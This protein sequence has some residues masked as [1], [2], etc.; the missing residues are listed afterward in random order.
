M[1]SEIE[2]NVALLTRLLDVTLHL[3]SRNLPFRGKTQTLGDVHNGNYLGTLELMSHYDPLLKDH[4][5]KVRNN[6]KGSRLAHYL[7]SDSQNEFIQLCAKRVSKSI[8][9]EREDAIYYSIIC[10]AT[11]DISHAEQN[12]LLIRYVHYNENE[13]E[14][15]ITERFTEFKQ[16][17]KKTGSE[18]A[19]MIE[20]MLKELGI[21]IS[22]CR[23]Q[24]YDNGANMSG[25]VK[26]VQAQILKT[27]N[28]ATFSACASHTLNLTGVHAAGSSEEVSTFFGFINCLYRFVSASPHR[29][30][31]YKQATG[32]SV[33]SLSDTR[34]SARIDAVKPIAKHLPSVIEALGKILSTCSLTN[35]AR[36]EAVGLQKYFMTFD[37]IVLLT[38][39][40]KVLHAIDQRNVILQSGKISLEVEAANIKSL[41]VEMQN[42]RNEWD[43]L[44]A[45]ATLIAT[46]LGIPPHFKKEV[47]RERKRKRF[48]DEAR[49]EENVQGIPADTFRNTVFYR[50][51][52]HIISDLDTRFQSTAN[53]VEE[54]AAIIKVGKLR[55]SDVAAV[56]RPLIHK[57]NKDLTPQFESKI[58]HLNDVFSATFPSDCSGID[59]LNAIYKM[60]LHSIFGEVCTAIRI[61]CTLPV[62]VAGGERAFSK[63]KLIKSYL[64]STM[65]QERLNSLAILSIE[66]ELARSLDFKDLIC[67]FAT[68]KARRLDFGI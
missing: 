41:K 21:D 3:A 60:Q 68:K 11:P 33:H 4:L 43:S 64:R 30:A 1:L 9:K 39:W 31:I 52:D 40:V 28:L 49:T 44:L 67:D 46:E 12:V 65:V 6:T 57:Y 25:K 59:L 8:L 35:D 37:A 63:L 23:G 53:I 51:M 47:S 32:C 26:G 55:E 10:D 50:A 13:N 36:A 45:E 15:Q 5:D 38:I 61:F 7:S 62:T 56:C 54:F 34:W 24:G 14:W 17:H 29:W 2:K 16:F 20:N 48:F 18:I 19:G 58:R 66:S 22:D 27:N 42:L